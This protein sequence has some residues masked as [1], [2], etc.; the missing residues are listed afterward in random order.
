MVEPGT[1][2][3]PE[4]ER[5]DLERLAI[6]VAVEAARLIVDERPADL[7]VHSTKS[8]LTDV[9]TV[10]DHRS[11]ALVIE[12]L[13]AA[14]PGDAVYGEERGGVSGDSGVTWVV[15]PIDGT[16]NY[17]YGIP[18]YAVSLAAV[19]GDPEVVGGFTPFVGVV[20]NPETGE[21]YHA[22]SGGGAWLTR[23]GGEPRRIV[24]GPGPEL[25]L[26]LVATGFGYV[27]ER[28]RWQARVL[29][30]VLP[31]VRDIRREGGAAL[32]LCHVATGRVD[33]FYESG[34]NAWDLAAAWV[35]ASEAGVVV[36]GLD[37]PGTPGP[38]L[39]WAAGAGLAPA[40]S[41]LVIGATRA[42]R[43]V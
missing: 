6:D 7:G 10:M 38:D 25:S 31:A 4:N 13:T 41:S 26:A 37:G 19:V 2:L 29:Q 33:A 18:A 3:P 34:L 20:V 35:V 9:V 11:Q 40:L 24:A 32:D 17:L 21:V 36:G 1:V 15:D 23:A 12:R 28:R 30:D 16:V 27:A 42:H 8:T 14:R 39:T 22:R 43:G 5:A